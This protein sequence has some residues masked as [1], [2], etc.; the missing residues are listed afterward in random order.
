MRRWKTMTGIKYTRVPIPVFF[1]LGDIKQPDGYVYNLFVFTGLAG[2]Y[3]VLFRSKSR[4][5]PVQAFDYMTHES[6]LEL[7]RDPD[8]VKTDY[9]QEFLAAQPQEPAKEQWDLKVLFEEGS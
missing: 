3:Y 6:A 4:K 2:N 5:I 8:F 1:R 9:C 7:I